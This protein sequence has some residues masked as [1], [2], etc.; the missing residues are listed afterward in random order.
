M[1]VADLRW[2][3]D[4]RAAIRHLAGLVAAG[5]LDREAAFAALME[6]ANNPPDGSAR[7]CGLAWQLADEI[8]EARKGSLPPSLGEIIDRIAARYRR[9]PPAAVWGSYCP[10][11]EPDLLARCLELQAAQR[12]ARR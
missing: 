10:A 7:R 2:V 1:N 6:A 9:N 3:R 11:Y 12:R 5:Q 8:A 4:H